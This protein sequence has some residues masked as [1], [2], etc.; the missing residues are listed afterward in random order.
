MAAY[1][2]FIASLNLCIGYALGV[3][4]GVLPGITPR[5]ESDEDHDDPIGLPTAAV[6]DS[7]PKPEQKEGAAEIPVEE[8]AA[9]E[10]EEV[11]ELEAA[12]AE[13]PGKV[14]E[15]SQ[16]DNHASIL[17]G[18]ANF[19]QKLDAVS[20]KLA[21]AEEDRETVDQCADEMKQANDE[22]LDQTSGAVESLNSTADDELSDADENMRDLLNRQTE[23]IRRANEEIDELMADDDTE[24][25]RK[26]LMQSSE[27]LVESAAVLEEAIPD[28]PLAS[29]EVE[30]SSALEPDEEPL[31]S[32]E[33]LLDE[34][35]GS[36][37]KPK[38]P[39]K[40]EKTPDDSL[41]LLEEL[42]SSI[43]EAIAASGSN[44]P[45][46][47]ATLSLQLDRDDAA[48]HVEALL[49]CVQSIVAKELGPG[50]QVTTTPEGTLLVTLP[51]DN[52][53]E[54]NERCER[55]RQQVTETTFCRAD[56]KLCASLVCSLTDT[57]GADDRHEVMQRLQECLNEAIKLGES[58]TFHHDGALAV[59]VPPL[60]LAISPQTMDF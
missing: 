34:L 25:V 47:V 35:L 16:V 29:E 28:G 52:V 14:D 20:E 19:K 3:Y 22:Y 10:A 45:L 23:E 36:S 57:K 15:P 39:P 54:A 27:Q 60:P 59:P 18:L 33:S 58:R 6:A 55:L 53:A 1:I 56:T 24:A 17:E 51:G 9:E 43:D 8:P 38:Q 4:I 26:K 40:V 5:R 37:S 21:E 44:R 32:A 12:V 30:S 46:Q 11:A 41:A 42:M 7:P 2:A 31:V 50:Q 48:V 49:E 13:V